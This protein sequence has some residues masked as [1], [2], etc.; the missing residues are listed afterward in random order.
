L[1]FAGTKYWLEKAD[2]RLLDSIDFALCLD[3]I[4][5]GQ[6]L[7]LH[8]SRSEKDPKAKQI[9]E[10]FNITANLMNLPFEVIQKKINISDDEVPWQHEQFSKKKLLA[11]S[12]SHISIP[13]DYLSRSNIFDRE[14]EMDTLTKNVKFIGEALGRIIYSLEKS[15]VLVF[16]DELDL[17]QEY[18]HSWINTMAKYPRV[19]PYLVSQQ[20]GKEDNTIIAGLEKELN[21]F[22]TDVSKKIAIITKDFNEEIFFYDKITTQMSA[23]RGKPVIFDLALTLFVILYLSLLYTYLKG[24]KETL[25]QIKLIFA[26][27]TKKKGKNK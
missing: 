5:T 4:G 2:Q 17:S 10:A 25:S 22:T 13:M 15:Q 19:A 18:I 3:T 9:Y 6:G 16:S 12:I 14:V 24:T 27:T 21:K 7:K 11:G 8:V 23:Y 26:T 1:N 20:K